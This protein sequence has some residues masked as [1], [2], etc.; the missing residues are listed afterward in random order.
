MKTAA[1]AELKASLSEYLARVKSGEEVLVTDRGSPI[2]KIIPAPRS[3]AGTAHL[4]ELEKAG[5]IAIGRGKLPK[6]FW[7]LPRPADPKGTVLSALLE[8]R[9]ETR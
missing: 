3:G 8:E 7:S 4:R 1:V 6:D 2:A 5:L 9:R